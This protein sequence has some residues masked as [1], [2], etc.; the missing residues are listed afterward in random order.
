MQKGV[1][2][3]QEAGNDREMEKVMERVKEMMMMTRKTRRVRSE[4]QVRRCALEMRLIN[5]SKIGRS[6]RKELAETRELVGFVSCFVFG[7]NDVQTGN[8]DLDNTQSNIRDT[9]SSP[10]VDE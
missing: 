7:Q 5:A 1:E 10:W 3:K 9:R 6:P 4:T 2:E 8:D